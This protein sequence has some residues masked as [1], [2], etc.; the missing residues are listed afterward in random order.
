MPWFPELAL[1]AEL[2]RKQN[3]ETGHTDP[4][5]LYLAALNSGTVHD[6]EEVWPGEIILDDP[7][8]GEIRGHRR[9]QRFVRDSRSMLASRHARI[10]RHGSLVDGERAV[11]ELTVDLTSDGREIS[12]PVAIVAESPHEWSVIFRSYYRPLDGSHEARPPILP[13]GDAR[14]A[15][16]VG[17]FV[18]AL[19]SADV[20]GAVAAFAPDAYLSEPDGLHRGTAGLTEFFTARFAAGGVE[21]EECAI[22]DDGV[23]CAFE[24]NRGQGGARQAA[25]AVFE[26]G[27]DGLLT[28]VRLYEDVVPS[29]GG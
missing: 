8:A 26:R 7:Q 13:P 5:G 23:R 20:P 24:F 25:I 10:N 3:R 12:W 29:T 21:I 15:G 18:A 1:A 11:I 19:R 2:A 4:V 22:T 27:A 14:P 16:V 9:L 28:A 17:W 6:L